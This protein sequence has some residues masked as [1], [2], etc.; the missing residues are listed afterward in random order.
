MVMKRST[1]E[2]CR[3]LSIHVFRKKGQWKSMNGN[4]T[5]SRGDIPYAWAFFTVQDNTIILSWN[6]RQGT[7][8]QTIPIT[9]LR[10]NYGK[11]YFFQCP[12]CNRRAVILYL[13]QEFLCRKCHKLTYESCQESHTRFHRL[14]RLTDSQFRNFMKVS[15][16]SR[17]LQTNKRAGKR[18]LQRLQRYIDKSGVIF[19]G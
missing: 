11:R 13:E 16:Y 3:K 4:T 10:V 15:A 7:V 2:D 19:T 18:M 1:V 12:H 5:W 9:A 14:L 6:G 17:E 8:T